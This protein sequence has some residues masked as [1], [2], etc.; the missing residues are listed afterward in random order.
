MTW[1]LD[2]DDG[3]L[4]ILTDVTGPAARMGH[5]L[6]IL[7]AS[8]TATVE[9]TGEQPSAM[10]LTADTTSLTVE[11]GDGGV[12]PL[13]GPERALA[14][15]NALKT[16][17]VQ[18]YPTV[19]FESHTVTPTETGYRLT[20]ELLLHGHRR[21]H[22]VDLEVID[23]GDAWQLSARSAV[24]QTD[25]GVKPFSMFMG[26]MKVADVVTVA[27]TGRVVK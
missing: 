16:L 13:S 3:D 20:G 10:S 21:E 25:F 11:S 4:R 23:T 9:W 5:R 22:S 6:S 12:T 18:R 2:A 24:R 14:R 17:S 1:T 8:W 15:T 26:S 19:S 27:F 7:V